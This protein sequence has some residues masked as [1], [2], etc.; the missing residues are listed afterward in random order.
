VPR[1]AHGVASGDPLADRVVLW[2]RVEADEASIDVAWSVARDPD[3]TDVVATGVVVAEASADHTVHV[4]VSGLDE[5]TYHWYRFEADGEPSPVGRTRTLPRDPSRI[6]FAYTSCAKHNAGFFN[7]Y[8]RIA[9][10]DDI[11]F[12]LHLGDYIYEASNTPPASQTPG[13]DIGRPFD[14]LHECLTLDDYRTRYRQ[15]HRD[16]DLQALHQRHPIIPTSDDHELA[17]G[18]WRD[19]AQEHKPE[20]GT[21]AERKARAF[22]ARYEWLPI[23]PPDPADPSRVWR[24]VSLGSLAEIFLLDTRS[25]RDQ[26]VPGNAMGDPGRTALGPDQK[27]WLFDGLRSSS[28]R[29]RLLGNP[30]VMAQSWLPDLPDDVKPPLKKLKL[31]ADDLQG[32]D[33]DQWD[34]YPV[35]R[36][37]VL[38]VIESVGRGTTVVLSADVHVGIAI[39]LNQDAHERD[40]PVCIELVSPSISSQNLDEKMQWGY[41]QESLAAEARML[42]AL[43]HWRWV[44]TDSNGYLVVD[45]DHDRIHAE[46]W[47][48]PT[49]L[50][51]VAGESMGVAVEAAHGVPRLTLLD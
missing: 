51:R 11:S 10:R 15:Y 48:V 27:A 41:R 49:V 7:V 31:L 32:P 14:P 18:A 19:G 5:D 42:E 36:K 38:D 25:R 37:E 26:P 6:R 4:D 45:L 1:F 13:A 28:A 40:E 50:E 8:G 46:F 21:W 12:L 29:W 2:T 9:D 35:E 47:V 20:Y 43:P 24:S 17:D 33:W 3:L 34:G 16:P 23:R 30:S 44:D 22:Q 39:E